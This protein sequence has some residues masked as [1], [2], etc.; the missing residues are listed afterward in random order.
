MWLL[1]GWEPRLLPA[2]WRVAL[3]WTK[4]RVDLEP[5]PKTEAP[6]PGGR[7]WRWDPDGAP[8]RH[9]GNPRGRTRPLSWRLQHGWE[10]QLSALPGALLLSALLTFPPALRGHQTAEELGGQ[11]GRGAPAGRLLHRE[12]WGFSREQAV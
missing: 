1:G 8:R 2:P 5:W 7:A 9:K 3:S 6:L 12:P 11:P 4:L 10:L